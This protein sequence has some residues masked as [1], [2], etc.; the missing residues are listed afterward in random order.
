LSRI[1]PESR[2]LWAW[3]DE[4]GDPWDVLGSSPTCAPCWVGA[5]R[6]AAGLPP[7]IDTGVVTL[8]SGYVLVCGK[9]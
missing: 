9:L 7:L 8:Y 3:L 2:S 5:D 4:Q 1:T 6:A